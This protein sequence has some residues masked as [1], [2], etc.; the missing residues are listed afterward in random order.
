M[1]K[2]TAVSN[3]AGSNMQ[4]FRNSLAEPDRV[5]VFALKAGNFPGV[6]KRV[7]S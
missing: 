1:D 6:E 4:A 3:S 2:E 7:F 5:A